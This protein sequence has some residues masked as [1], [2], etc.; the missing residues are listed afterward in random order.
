MRTGSLASILSKRTLAPTK[1]DEIKIKANILSAF[2]HE[3]FEAVVGREAD[4][5]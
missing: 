5:L 1:L 3:K 4:E 2:V